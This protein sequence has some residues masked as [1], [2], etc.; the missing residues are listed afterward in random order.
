MT[1][2]QK[3]KI[4][5]LRSSGMGYKA[6]A[7]VLG[8]SRDVVRSFCKKYGLEGNAAV[9]RENIELRVKNG[10]LCACCSKP[11]KQPKTGRKRKFC[12]EECRRAWWKKNTDKHGRR[13]TAL[14]KSDC[15]YCGITFESYGNKSR[16]YCCHECY[17]KDRFD[18]KE[19]GSCET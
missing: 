9:I 15:A 7:N 18:K 3:N 19:N 5:E 8:L 11:L 10:V 6:I 16:K 1:D 4:P 14:Y 17:I 12:S 2:Y 13:D